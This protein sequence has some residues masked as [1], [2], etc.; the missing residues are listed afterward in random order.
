MRDWR[1]YQSWVLR[2]P[3]GRVKILWKAR[4]G[5]R[6]NPTLSDHRASTIASFAVLAVGFALFA[7]PTLIFVVQE[8][9]SR[10]DGAHG[11]IVLFTGLWLIWRQWGEAISARKLPNGAGVWGQF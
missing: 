3:K 2:E 1:I 5:R 11:P 4:P 9:W 10:E 6:L 8:Y 7:I